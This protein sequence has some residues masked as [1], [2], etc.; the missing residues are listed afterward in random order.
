[1]GPTSPVKRFACIRIGGGNGGGA[2]AGSDALMFARALVSYYLMYLLVT[3]SP[4]CA[5]IVSF[6]SVLWQGGVRPTK[7]RAARRREDFAD[8][9]RVNGASPGSAK[10][11]KLCC[12]LF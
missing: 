12:S 8:V 7:S 11:Y 3:V 9:L 4:S 10:W 1:M 6:R 2:C 5:A